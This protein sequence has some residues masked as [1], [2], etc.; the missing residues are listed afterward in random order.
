MDRKIFWAVLTYKSPPETAPQLLDISAQAAVNGYRRIAVRPQRTDMVRNWLIDIFMRESTDPHD[1]LIM[2]DEDHMHP[3][4]ILQRLV[5]WDSPVVG[6]LSF[7][8]GPNY[9]PLAWVWY[10]K[11]N[12]FRAMAEWPKGALMKVDAVGVNAC[13]IQRGAILQCEAWGLYRPYFRYEYKPREEWYPSE[14]MTWF[15]ACVQAGIECYCDTS[16]VSPHLDAGWVEES[17]WAEWVRDHPQELPPKVGGD[18]VKV[19]EVIPVKSQ[20]AAQV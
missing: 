11:D 7:K 18:E 19:E 20:E 5:A 12:G 10:P 6:G 13:A 1:T 15:R 9:S 4:D 3:T 17:S 8:R 16:L 14:D 2:L